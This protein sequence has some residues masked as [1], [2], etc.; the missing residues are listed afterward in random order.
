MHTKRIAIGGVKGIKWVA[1]PRGPHKKTQSKP[2]VSIIKELGYADKGTEAR[3]IIIWGMVEVDGVK[4][5]DKNFGAGLMDIIS[6]PKIKKHYRVVSEKN[7]LV[8]K[9][10]SEKESKIKVCKVIGK[11]L[12]PQGKSQ[13]TFHDGYVLIT[14]K[15]IKVDDSVVF[16]L[17]ERKIKEIIPYQVG[18]KAIVVNGRHTGHHG[19]IKEIIE[20]SAQRK[21]QTKVGDTQ[22]LTEYIFVIG[23]DKPV[24]EL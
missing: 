19:E 11:K 8:I 6:L 15:K 24:I 12:Q 9:D 2:L 18:V 10:I 13:I 21:S 20:G 23:K 16:D 22:T 3:K 5:K 4:R 1:T 7:G 14:D 17:P